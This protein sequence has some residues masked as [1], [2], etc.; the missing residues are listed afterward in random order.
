MLMGAVLIKPVPRLLLLREASRP[1]MLGK[2]ETDSDTYAAVPE[3][4]VHL[5]KISLPNSEKSTHWLF[6]Q[7][8]RRKGYS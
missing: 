6:N 3:D 5:E 2:K 4:V 8:S 7:S 1:L